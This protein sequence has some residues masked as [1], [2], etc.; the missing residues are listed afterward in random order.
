MLSSI[1]LL[2]YARVTAINLFH[3]TKLYVFHIQYTFIKATYAN[4]YLPFRTIPS[5]SRVDIGVGFSANL[6]R[7]KENKKT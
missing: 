5:Q 2:L 7:L 1:S 3:F 4:D 6:R